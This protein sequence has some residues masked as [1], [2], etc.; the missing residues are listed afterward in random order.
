MDELAVAFA[1]DVAPPQVDVFATPKLP[2]PEPHP[3]RSAATNSG[4][5]AGISFACVKNGF[6]SLTLCLCPLASLLDWQSASTAWPILE[7]EP[8]WQRPGLNRIVSVIS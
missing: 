1:G 8:N 6:I 3:E 2:Q 7:H 5:T 4:T